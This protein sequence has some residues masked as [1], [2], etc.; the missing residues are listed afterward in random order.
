MKTLEKANKILLNVLN[1][2]HVLTVKCAEFQNKRKVFCWI[3]SFGDFDYTYFEITNNEIKLCSDSTYNSVARNG[4][5][6][7]ELCMDCDTLKNNSEWKI[8][9]CFKSLNTRYNNK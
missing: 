4:Q 2:S 3:S 8:T 7:L 6:L 9:N 1:F 5:F